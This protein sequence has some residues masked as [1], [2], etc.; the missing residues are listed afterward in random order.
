MML[1][2]YALETPRFLAEREFLITQFIRFMVSKARPVKYQSRPIKIQL[3][4]KPIWIRKGYQSLSET[5]CDSFSVFLGGYNVRKGAVNGDLLMV[6]ILD[7]AVSCQPATR[8]NAQC[9]TIAMRRV[10]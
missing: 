4:G 8:P 9:N 5:T 2:R 7:I 1:L 3:G 10:C 6:T